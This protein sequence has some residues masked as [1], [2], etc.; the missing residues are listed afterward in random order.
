MGHE[1]NVRDL[2]A[3]FTIDPV[4]RQ[5][6]NESKKKLLLIQGDH[7]SEIFGF[8]CPRYVE[9]HDMSLCNEVEV[10]YFNYDTQ[11]NKVNSGIYDVDDLQ[12]GEDE[13]T[14][15]FSWSISG[16][17]TQLHGRL[18]FLIRFKCKENGIVT[19][20]WN[21]AF[22]TETNI[23]KGS[24]ADSLFEKEYVDI[25][26]QWKAKVMQT[27]KDDLTAWK[28]AKAQELAEHVESEV[29][30]HS[31]EWNQALAVE[32]ARIDQF[33]RLEEG[34]T[35]GDAE[36]MD[37]RVDFEGTVHNT[38][39]SAVRSTTEVL[40]NIKQRAY[41]TFEA[42]E[43]TVHT[44][45]VYQVESKAEQAISSGRYT[46]YT[47]TDEKLLLMG[48]FSWSSY[49]VFPLG[50]F[51]D[52]E[53]NLLKKVGHTESAIFSDLLVYVPVGANSLVVNGKQWYEPEVKRFVAGDLEGDISAIQKTL[54][55]QIL[56][57]Q[58]KNYSERVLET[59]TIGLSSS[60]TEL[61]EAQM[62]KTE[63]GLTTGDIGTA[64]YDTIYFPVG[65]YESFLLD[66]YAIGVYG[67]AF[68]DSDK[69]WISSFGT[70]YPNNLE[71]KVV[72][73]NAHYIAIT[74]PSTARY[75][76]IVGYCRTFEL[77]GM[78]VDHK[79]VLNLWTGKKI[80]WIGTSVPFGQYAKTSYPHE[81]AEYLGF[82]LVNCSSPGIAIHTGKD[83]TVLK[84]GSLSLSKEEYEAIGWTI[85][86][87][88]VEYVPGGSYNDYYRTYENVLCEANAD[89]DLYVFDV[90]PNNSNF[91]TSDWDMFDFKNWC[92]NDGSDFADHR[93]TFLGALLFL[94]DKMYTLNE[95]ARM[96]FIIGSGFSY[97]EGKNSFEK[98]SAKWNIPLLDIWSKVNISPKSLKKV[99]S[100][101]GTNGHP[102][103]FAHELMGKML[104]HDLLSVY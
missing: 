100:E 15:E 20:A 2:D 4:T 10:H 41:G 102:S 89:A 29:A 69:N 1:H 64:V 21:T 27:F 51:Y 45:V 96:I 67:G 74:V 53:G 7:N 24:N 35:T 86:S 68:V 76:N 93:T 31:A 84:Y 94:M 72:P 78:K 79:N 70:D 50:A 52:S 34:S 58:L 83:N 61:L 95:N 81:A 48:G 22:F 28:T 54:S 44:D 23:G 75:K 13:N 92:Y 57:S 56:S 71:A 49:S 88:P 30:S 40:D 90:V 19:Y 32:R 25:I 8:R 98:V 97:L 12:V 47:I 26:E 11:T 37:A 16:N 99:F 46:E 39:G 85:P 5:I 55:S 17:G 60:N 43:G 59:K 101:G 65:I 73:E 62:Y 42:L 33:K 104:A 66:E 14:V 103:T 38:A 18:E 9:S 63:G 6:K 3:R 82:N 91:D 80:V 87:E 77:N 36:L